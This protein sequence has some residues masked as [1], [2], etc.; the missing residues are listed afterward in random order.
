[1]HPCQH[2]IDVALR[3]VGVQLDGPGHPARSAPRQR[4]DEALEEGCVARR[5]HLCELGGRA[6][7]VCVGGVM[8]RYGATSVCTW[9][10]WSRQEMPCSWAIDPHYH[11]QR[12]VDSQNTHSMH[13]TPPHTPKTMPPHARVAVQSRSIKT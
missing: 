13:S 10:D 5:R 11:P 6:M 9:R 12:V 2:V 1:V 3:V 7:C 8:W 4:R